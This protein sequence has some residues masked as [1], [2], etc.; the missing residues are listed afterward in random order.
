M[1]QEDRGCDTGGQ[2]LLYRR[3]VAVLQEDRGCDTV[4]Q[5]L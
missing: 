3:T 4:G 2:R 5:T 1:I